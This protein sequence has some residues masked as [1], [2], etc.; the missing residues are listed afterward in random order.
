MCILLG[1]SRVVL[2]S[3]HEDWWQEMRLSSFGPA[4][5]LASKSTWFTGSVNRAVWLK[6]LYVLH[7][8]TPFTCNR[9]DIF[10][11]NLWSLVFFFNWLRV[12]EARG[13]LFFFSSVVEHSHSFCII[14]LFY[15]SPVQSWTKV[16]FVKYSKKC[17]AGSQCQQDSLAQSTLSLR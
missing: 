9:S 3:S 16:P 17:A 8:Q 14:L 7:C 13:V 6:T 15:L 11:F 12:T 2:L 10:C 5:D 4:L 1:S